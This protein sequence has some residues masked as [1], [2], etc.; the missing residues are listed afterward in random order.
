MRRSLRHPIVPR[1]EPHVAAAFAGV[2]LIAFVMQKT[3]QRLEQKRPESAL[4]SISGLNE[5]AFDY[6]AKKIL[7]EILCVRDG[8]ALP[9]DK[10]E[11]RSPINLAKLGKRSLRLLFIRCGVR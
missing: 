10:S 2:T 9:A 5:T 11:N 8:I 7:S 6:S 4:I 3:L 1:N